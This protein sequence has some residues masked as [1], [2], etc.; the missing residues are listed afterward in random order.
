MLK[1]THIP[2]ILILHCNYSI[3]ILIKILSEF[4]MKNIYIII[5]FLILYNCDYDKYIG[6]D[7]NAEEL[8]TTSPVQGQIIHFYTGDPVTNA[9]VK[10]G[11]QET[12]TNI[13]GF[14]NLNYVLS[15]DEER[16]K[17][18]QI[19][20]T[21]HNYYP[22]SLTTIIEP[23]GN[24]HNFQLKYDAPIIIKAARRITILEIGKEWIKYQ[25]ICQ[26]I[27]LDYQGAE[28][29]SEAFARF[30]YNES[31]D[32]LYQPLVIKS[33]PSPDT[34]Y[35]Q[36]VY[37]GMISFDL[38]YD[39][40]VQDEDGYSDMLERANNRFQEDELLFNPDL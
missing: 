17:P 38:N 6:Y 25:V 34:G 16:N 27:V 31:A 24:R 33:M 32:T 21:A 29:I 30:Y 7:T 39:I 2:L 1:I 8:L 35:F 5:S 19:Q 15:G 36:S 11:M 13:N 26:A 28:D 37:V 12:L 3:N 9:L 22:E 4:A 10:V 18:I 14:Y 40:N 20:V 23:L